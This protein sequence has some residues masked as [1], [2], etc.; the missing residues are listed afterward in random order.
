[1]AAPVSGAKSS[2]DSARQDR[3][4][5]GPSRSRPP[6]HRLA[7]AGASRP[8]EPEPRSRLGIRLGIL[9]PHF[10]LGL[11]VTVRAGSA[12][13]K[14][15]PRK[16]FRVRRAAAAAAV[17]LQRCLGAAP[18]RAGESCGSGGQ[19]TRAGA[20]RPGEP[21]PRELLRRCRAWRP[22]REWPSAWSAEATRR[23]RVGT[24]FLGFGTNLRSVRFP[25]SAPCGARNGRCGLPTWVW[26]PLG[27]DRLGAAWGWEVGHDG[28][29]G[30][31]QI[32][33]RW[34]WTA[35]AASARPRTTGGGESGRYAPGRQC[36]FKPAHPSVRER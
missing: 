8:S 24:R 36:L 27:A 20:C 28:G 11:R 31:A 3:P 16:R 23:R 10:R 4:S 5:P 9:R 33:L 29:A 6:A 18:A 13:R 14:P 7:I 2:T 26:L 32:R 30:P 22:G 17:G 34:V 35:P 1:M 15:P 25:D 19:T 21:H 12:A